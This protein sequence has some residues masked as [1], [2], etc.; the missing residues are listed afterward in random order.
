MTP[1]TVEQIDSLV[2]FLEP[3]AANG[4]VAGEWQGRAGQFPWFDFVDV[5]DEFLQALYRQ[6]WVSPECNWTEW[7]DTA[8]TF[9][10]EPSKI[11]TADA[12]TIR[13]LFTTHVRANRFCEGHLASMF[14]NGHIVLLLRRLQ[15][16]RSEMERA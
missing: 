13:K 14:E 4:F 1:V 10:E 12:Q 2:P 5:V 11:E 8:N 7:Q 6:N 16:I 15:T 9:M 3:F